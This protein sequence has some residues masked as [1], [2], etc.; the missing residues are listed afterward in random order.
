MKLKVI[1]VA[2]AVGAISLMPFFAG[3]DPETYRDP[4]D[5]RGK[6]DVRRVEVVGTG[7]VRYKVDTYPSW[8]V[9]DVRDRGFVLIFFDTFGG[10]RFDYYVLVR[11]TGKKMNATLW[12]DRRRKR[13]FKVTSV[14]AWRPG[15]RSVSVRVPTGRMKWPET[16]AF[17]RWRVQT[18][19]MG[20]N[21]RR[22]C[23][24]L[25]P[26]QGA[27]TVH[28]P[29]ATPS[30]SPTGTPSPDPTGSPSPAPTETPP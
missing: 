4:N 20:R 27:V 11:S 13:D 23:F 30:P 10:N 6:L 21:C 9:A 17:Y 24:D 16:R 1:A 15:P 18:L 19:F 26:D 8:K 28:R 29:G 3:A 2:A 12:R 14:A 5:A 7:R 25:V 22:V